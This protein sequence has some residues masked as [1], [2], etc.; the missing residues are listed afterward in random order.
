MPGVAGRMPAHH[1]PHRSLGSHRR[2][3]WVGGQESHDERVAFVRPVV[4]SQGGAAWTKQFYEGIFNMAFL[5]WVQTNQHRK[6]LAFAPEFE[7]QMLCYAHDISQDD[8]LQEGEIA[9]CT[10][11][12]TFARAGSSCSRTASA[13]P[14]RRIPMLSTFCCDLQDMCDLEAM[15]KNANGG[16]KDN[17]Q[18]P[19]FLMRGIRHEDPQ[20]LVCLGDTVRR[21]RS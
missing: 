1:Q 13:R 5:K 19:G 18:I 20:N 2:V 14:R 6:I 10:N 4:R 21:Q 12:S 17:S 15:C 9:A 7:N 3:R 8:N 16:P 11:V